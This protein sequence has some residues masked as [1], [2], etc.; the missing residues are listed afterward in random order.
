VVPVAFVMA[1]VDEIVD[2]V[3]KVVVVEILAVAV[4]VAV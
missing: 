2:L 3:R 4:V 1:L